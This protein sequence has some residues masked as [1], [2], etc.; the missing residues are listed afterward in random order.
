[1]FMDVHGMITAGKGDRV[2]MSLRREGHK[3]HD[4]SGVTASTTTIPSGG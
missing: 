3:C 2:M 4:H 1:M